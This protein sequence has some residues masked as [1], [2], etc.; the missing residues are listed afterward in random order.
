MYAPDCPEGG[1]LE[2]RKRERGCAGQDRREGDETL[3]GLRGVGVGE[4]WGCSIKGPARVGGDGPASE[5]DSPG[6]R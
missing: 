3:V 2:S 5:G 4:A 1:R 6:R